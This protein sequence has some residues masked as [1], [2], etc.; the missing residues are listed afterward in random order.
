MVRVLLP[1]ARAGAHAVQGPRHHYLWHVLRLRPGDALEVFDGEGTAF[2][3][4]VTSADAAQL[5]LELGQGHAQ[6]PARAVTV[7]QGLPKAERLELILQKCTELGAAAFAPAQCERC[8]VKLDGKEAKKLERWA[9]I[10][11]EAARQCGRADVPAVRP[12]APLLDVVRTLPDAPAVLVLD[13]EERS[14]PLRAA[15]AVLAGDRPIALVVGP[16]GGL[17]RAEVA[18]LVAAGATCVTLGRLVLRTETAAL[19][20]LAVLRHLDGELG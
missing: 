2:P 13:E 20:A 4:T 12:P 14:L 8:V 18:A 11:E 10:V 7:V 5:T 9:R 3:A 15:H 19:A 1:G 17:T 6:R 16:E